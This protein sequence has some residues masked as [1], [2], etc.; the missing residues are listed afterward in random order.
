MM[1][2]PRHRKL[3]ARQPPSSPPGRCLYQD[4]KATG[5]SWVWLDEYAVA[6]DGPASRRVP[7]A[8]LAGAGQPVQW[9]DG[10]GAKGW[11]SPR[12]CVIFGT[13]GQRMDQV[14]EY[15]VVDAR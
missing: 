8:R 12:Q 13:G 2:T 5:F 1:Q 4:G 7:G 14:A 11:T 3:G 10:D 9:V 6:V 15:R